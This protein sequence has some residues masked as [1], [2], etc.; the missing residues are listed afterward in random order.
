MFKSQD[1]ADICKISFSEKLEMEKG[2]EVW[3]RGVNLSH[4]ILCN[5]PLLFIKQKYMCIN[6]HLK[7]EKQ[8]VLK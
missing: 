2:K 7:Q 3:G 1:P 4:V 5:R 6:R 8:R